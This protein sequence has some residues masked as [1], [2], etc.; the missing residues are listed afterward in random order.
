MDKNIFKLSDLATVVR[1]KNAGPFL[2]TLDV[3]FK[4]EGTLK[5]VR[6]SGAITGPRIAE[7]YSIREGDIHEITFFEP[8][9][10]LKITL[11]RWISSASPGDTDV[12]GAQQHVPLM[13]L[14]VE[15][16]GTDSHCTSFGDLFDRRGE[17]A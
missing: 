15:I 3:F 6:D 4:D 13:N 1:S 8:A 7:A 17:R 9:A 10:A 12:F 11:K 16:N 5:I 2:I 14:E